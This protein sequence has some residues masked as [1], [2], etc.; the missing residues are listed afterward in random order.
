MSRDR[1]A[2]DADHFKNFKLLNNN[3]L[4]EEKLINEISAFHQMKNEQD[5]FNLAVILLDKISEKLALLT[6]ETALHSIEEVT[7]LCT[8]DLNHENLNTFFNKIAPLISSATTIKN[9]EV[10]AAVIKPAEQ[11]KDP[12]QI[13]IKSHS[14]EENEFDTLYN[15]IIQILKTGEESNEAK[16][17]L[18]DLL[19]EGTSID[20]RYCDE[21]I[22]KRFAFEGNDAAV[23]LLIEHYH[24]NITMVIKGYKRSGQKEKI[25]ALSHKLDDSAQADELLEAE[26][27]YP[28]HGPALF[29]REEEIKQLYEKSLDKKQAIFLIVQ[30][31]VMGGH[32]KLAEQFI[33]IAR[34]KLKLN[35]ND[36]SELYEFAARGAA[37]GGHRKK[38]MEYIDQAI[39]LQSNQYTKNVYLRGVMQS[40]IA[41]QHYALARLLLPTIQ[42]TNDAPSITRREKVIA[43][44][45]S[46]GNIDFFRLIKD[47]CTQAEFDTIKKIATEKGYEKFLALLGEFSPAVSIKKERTDLIE[48][49]EPGQEFPHLYALVNTIVNLQK[50]M[51]S[52][53][54]EGSK[55]QAGET[56]LKE[57]TEELESLLKSGVSIDCFY[58]NQTIAERFASEQ[59]EAA[60]ALLVDH[61]HAN[62]ARV[63][64]GFARAGQID[65]VEDYRKKIDDANAYEFALAGAA[66]RGDKGLVAYLFN[67][68][69]RQQSLKNTIIR[70]AM[71]A[72]EEAL[73]LEYLDKSNPE[74]FESFIIGAATCTQKPDLFNKHNS[75]KA[76]LNPVFCAV[77][78]AGAANIQVIDFLFDNY[79]KNKGVFY[80]AIRYAAIH[81]HF[82]LAEYCIE[83]TLANPHIA[84]LIQDDCKLYGKKTNKEYLYFYAGNGAAGSGHKEKMME[85]YRIATN[86]NANLIQHHLGISAV[87]TAGF[88]NQYALVQWIIAQPAF[89]ANYQL[90]SP[91]DKDAFMKSIGERSFI[92]ILQ[93]INDKCAE[94]KNQ[95]ET[96]LANTITAVNSALLKGNTKF[97]SYFMKHYPIQLNAVFKN[98]VIGENYA[99]VKQCLLEIPTVC[100]SAIADLLVRDEKFR[101]NYLRQKKFLACLQSRELAMQLA[102]QEPLL[103]RE[104][105]QLDEAIAIGMLMQERQCSYEEACQYR[106]PRLPEDEKELFQPEGIEENAPQPGEN[107]A[108]PGAENPGEKKNEDEIEH[109]GLLAPHGLF[110][111]PEKNEQKISLEDEKKQERILESITAM[112]NLITSLP[113][114]YPNRADLLINCNQ[115]LE[116]LQNNVPGEASEQPGKPHRP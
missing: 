19:N 17:K 63:I 110:H 11:K 91:A 22:A 70:C 38:M 58:G 39:A 20:A 18:E 50:A 94:D 27:N 102:N 55:K 24:A 3:P 10:S 5:K 62:I 97:A 61:Y 64:R 57:T 15:L 66:G 13:E 29:K 33:D 93:L 103:K 32:F 30:S 23:K 111:P 79:P 56:E 53:Q 44:I 69:G 98:A 108:Q 112:L 37:M 87:I 34:N 35:Q 52:N 73:A 89:I 54:W 115:M 76:L 101:Q 99:L 81:G 84:G 26:L 95:E 48:G 86:G 100:I 105:V 6:E 21:T 41:Y 25:A 60:V 106:K 42:Y 80:G 113:E 96:I 71:R 36:L 83:K 116:N 16:L 8:P 51:E 65:R 43:S 78:A 59:N 12:H 45:A 72:G 47:S 49:D 75:N 82:R 9:K 7:K 46:T 14:E 40:I 74:E 1:P 31:A 90:M 68:A 2:N 77:F 4:F 107:I 88:N 85:Y 114:D 104:E 92:A 109:H 67:A 28:F